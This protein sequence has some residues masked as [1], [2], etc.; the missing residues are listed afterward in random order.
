[1][2]GYA[3]NETDE[4]MPLPIALAHKLAHRLADVRK[5]EVV[6]YLR[7]DGKTQVSVRYRDGRPVE[8]EKLLISTQHKEGAES[9]IPDD[10]WEHVV[11]PILPKDLYDA[12]Q[13]AQELPGQPDRP[14]RDRRPGG[15]RGPDRP[16]DHRRHL[17]RHGAPRRR[18]VLRQ[19]PEQGRPL[20]GLRGALRGQERRRGGPGRPLRGAGRLRDRRRAPGVGATSRRSG[21]RRSAAR[22]SPS[23]STST[24]TC[25]RA[26]S[27]STSSCTARSTRRPRRTA[28]SGATTTTS[29]GSAPTRPRRSAPPPGS[30]PSRSPDAPAAGRAGGR[31]PKPLR[32]GSAACATSRKVSSSAPR[33]R[34][35]RSRAATS[36]TTGGRGST[37][38]T[39]SCVESSGDAIDQWHRYEEDFAPARGRSGQNAHRLSLEWSRIEPAPGEFSG[40]ALEHYRR[41]LGTLEQHGLTAF[42]TLHHF[43]LPRWLAEQGG[44]LA[45]DAVERFARLRGAR[46]RGAR[47]PDAVRRRRSTSRRSSRFMGY[48]EGWFPP[49]MRSPGHFRLVTGRLDRGP[50]GGGGGGARRAAAT[51]RSASACSCRPIEP[52]RP[53]RPGLRGGVRGAAARSW[54][55]VYLEDLAGDWVGVQYYTRQRVDPAYAERLRARPGGRPADADGLGD[56]PGGAA[57][58]DHA[59]RRGTGLPVHVTENGIATADDAQR[60]DYLALAP[61]AGRPGAARGRRRARL[62]PLVSR[63]TTSSGPRAIARPSG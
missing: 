29:R 32:V 62:L 33:P 27:A 42:V 16:Q 12:Q 5:A 46:R 45:P 30:A 9:L 43:T 6:P 37:R 40:A 14:V 48:R 51:R 22:R 56:P 24:S 55:S 39:T 63:S 8:I 21:P 58:R 54:R 36:T 28:T 1:M 38:R 10:L 50:R 34:P 23:W 18:R 19:G 61:R 20:R 17:R 25:A 31:S 11:E 13:A 60:V 2:F 7:P 59:P 3:S 47:R 35:I 52:A 4:L 26:R 44:W 41:V 15:R 53:G 49:G 57:P